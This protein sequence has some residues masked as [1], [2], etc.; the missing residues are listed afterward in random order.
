MRRAPALS[1]WALRLAVQVLQSPLAWPILRFVF[2]KNGISK[3]LRDTEML[4]VP[5]FEPRWPTSLP[6]GLET[7]KIAKVPAGSSA[8]A[9]CSRVT[10]ASLTT[11]GVLQLL[12]YF[13]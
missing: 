10:S 3:V 9:A 4:D 2:A 11:S 12:S 13:P 7:C 1:G 6:A 5:T 8:T